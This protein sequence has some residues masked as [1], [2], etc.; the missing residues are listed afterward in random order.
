V[1]EYKS[2]WREVFSYS[3]IRNAFAFAPSPFYF[4]VFFMGGAIFLPPVLWVFTAVLGPDNIFRV[5]DSRPWLWH[6]LFMPPFMILTTL[7][8]RAAFINSK[9]RPILFYILYWVLLQVA[10]SLFVIPHIDPEMA[11]RLHL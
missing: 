9:A 11:E 1:Q 10:W 5:F 7:Y 3:S 8:N 2:F 4:V 6:F